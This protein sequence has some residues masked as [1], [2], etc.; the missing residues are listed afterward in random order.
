MLLC[1]VCLFVC[2]FMSHL[3]MFYSY[4]NV[5]NTVEAA[6]FD[7][8][9]ALIALSREGSLACH[10]ASVYYGHLRGSVTLTH[11]AERLAVKLSL[12][13]FTT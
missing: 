5:T 13:V 1:F 3:R 2:F 7:L 9:S 4:G 8:C 6:N 10:S 11:V 12:S